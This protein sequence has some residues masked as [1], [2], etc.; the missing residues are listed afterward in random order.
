MTALKIAKECGILEENAIAIEGPE[1]RNLSDTELDA[2]LPNLRVIARS[3]PS[4]KHKLV[5]RLKEHHE[6]VA[7]TGDGTN[8]GPALK[9]ADV[10][11]E[12]CL[13][14][15]DF[16]DIGIAMGIAGTEVAK[17]ASDI[18]IMDDNFASIVKAVMWGRVVRQNLQKFLQ[19][20]LTINF[21]SIRQ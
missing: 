19:F 20:Q 2:I 16:N 6:V 7:V 12:K 13:V 10:G 15:V 5:S 3:T 11:K 9:A 1:F 18:I 8:D 17:E 14:S 4:D 21:V